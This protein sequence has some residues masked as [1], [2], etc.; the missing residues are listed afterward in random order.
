MHFLNEDKVFQD[1]EYEIM[2]KSMIRV[3]CKPRPGVTRICIKP[4][5]ACSIMMSDITKLGL[6]IKQVF[7]YRNSVDTIRS[8]M[9]AMSYDP[10]L[11]ILRLFTDTV[12][13]SNLFP[14]WRNIFRYYFMQKMKDTSC[15]RMDATT[16]CVFTYSWANQI[17]IARDVMSRDR[18][19]L[20]VKYEDILSQSTKVVNKLFEYSGVDTKH[21]GRALIALSRDSQRGSGVSRANLGDTS[22]RHLSETDTKQCDAILSQYNLSLLGEDFRV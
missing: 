20:S 13:L 12:W 5:P 15:L 16:A 17:L 21:I 8:W 6:N 18:S 10:Y 3:M 4:R 11:V 9:A 22:Y 2:L 1:S 19:I 14:F 7:I